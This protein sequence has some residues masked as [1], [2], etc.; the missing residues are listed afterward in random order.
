MSEH[1]SYEIRR[2]LQEM[3]EEYWRGIEEAEDAV[4]AETRDYVV[5]RLGDERFGLPTRV[6]REV[7]RSPRLVRVPRVA[8]H[9]KG[10]INL[11]GQIVAVTDLRPLLGLPGRDLPAGGRLVVV[12]AAGVTTALLAEKVE[13]IRGIAAD[14]IE[15]FTEGLGAFPREA[16]AGQVAGEEGL[17]MLL[18]M[19]H[20]LSRPE[21]VIDQKGE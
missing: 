16:M 10:V 20:I 8:E 3:R 1:Q 19:D 13:G 7:L 14:T 18:D 5:I 4:A 15:P 9:I 6:A 12:E 21:F 2:V 17:L 11:R